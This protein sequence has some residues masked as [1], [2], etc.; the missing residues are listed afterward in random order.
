MKISYAG[1]Q[2]KLQEINIWDSTCERNP[3]YKSLAEWA[4]E[5]PEICFSTFGEPNSWCLDIL[6]FANN[7]VRFELNDMYEMHRAMVLLKQQLTFHDVKL[8]TL[9]FRSMWKFM[10]RN[11]LQ[12]HRD[13]LLPWVESRVPKTPSSNETITTLKRRRGMLEIMSD[14]ACSIQSLVSHYVSIEADGLLVQC[15]LAKC[16]KNVN[17]LGERVLEYLRNCE[18]LLSPLLIGAEVGREERDRL[19]QDLL[20]YIFQTGRER[21]EIPILLSWMTIPA[22]KAFIK[23][24]LNDNK[25][26]PISMTKYNEWQ[27]SEFEARH[28]DIVRWMCSRATGLQ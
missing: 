14:A 23:T 8:A 4:F 2:K 27:E 19:I 13:K 6:T 15:N 5:V 12:W 22:K 26:R 3:L 21:M 18:V 9:W 25:V 11:L 20:L 10:S 1:N 16:I 17:E 24:F 28:R 7:A